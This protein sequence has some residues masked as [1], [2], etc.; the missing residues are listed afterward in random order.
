MKSENVI[1]TVLL[2]KKKNNNK[3]IK[4]YEKDFL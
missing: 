2:K 4:L 3:K 1:D